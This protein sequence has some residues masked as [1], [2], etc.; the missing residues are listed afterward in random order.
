MMTTF[1]RARRVGLVLSFA[2]SCMLMVGCGETTRP[3]ATAKSIPLYEAFVMTLEVKPG[4]NPFDPDD[5]A[6][7]VLLRDESDNEVVLP[8]VW[9]QDCSYALSED[10]KTE[11]F[12]P[13]GRPR[14][15][16]R[17]APREKGRYDY[18][19][20][21]RRGAKTEEKPGGTFIVTDPTSDGP[22]SGSM[23]LAIGD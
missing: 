5:I 8:A 13:V 16:A 7:D 9:Y 21:I 12:T 10:K 14:F 20:R 11:T 22:V 19:W 23:T 4:G 17:S 1:Y 3:T 18:R 6:V 15:V 2:V